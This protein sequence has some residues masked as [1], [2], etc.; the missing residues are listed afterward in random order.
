MFQSVDVAKILLPFRNL[1]HLSAL[2]FPQRTEFS[3]LTTLEKIR[4]PPNLQEV[5]LSGMCSGREPFPWEHFICNW[6]DSLHHVTL[7]DWQGIS[8]L[9]KTFAEYARMPSALRS[10][11]IT[12]L[13]CDRY[14]AKFMAD[15]WGVSFLSVPVNISQPDFC[16][17]VPKHTMLEQLELRPI[18]PYGPQRANI[19]SLLDDEWCVE[20]LQRIRVHSAVTG[21]HDEV[22]E[23]LDA[24]LKRHNAVRNRAGST[25]IDTQEAGVVFF[26]E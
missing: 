15:I 19:L 14:S 3:S 5:T 6:P 4:W 25:N 21:G 12:D 24:M 8:S 18:S 10:V 23:K 17:G 11:Y 1:T 16:A 20:S 13:N 9:S 2:G 7:D 22:L 26:D